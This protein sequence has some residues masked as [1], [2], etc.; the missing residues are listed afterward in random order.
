MAD[1]RLGC[2]CVEHIPAWLS[3]DPILLDDYRHDLRLLARREGGGLVEGEIVPGLGV[4]A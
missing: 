4:F 3:I 1:P 2:R